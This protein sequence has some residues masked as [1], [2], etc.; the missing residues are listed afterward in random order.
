MEKR[1]A[2]TWIKHFSTLLGPYS[3]YIVRY[4]VLTRVVTSELQVSSLGSP[5]PFITNMRRGLCQDPKEKE[6]TQT[7]EMGLG[8]PW[9]SRELRLQAS[10][11]GAQV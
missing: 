5:F 10:N 9:W 4:F 1:T 2:S 11:A 8:L 3:P 7:K 6:F